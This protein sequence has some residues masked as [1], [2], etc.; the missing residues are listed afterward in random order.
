MKRIVFIVLTALLYEVAFAQMGFNSEGIDVPADHAVTFTDTLV[1]GGGGFR[2][3]TQLYIPEGEGPWPTVVLRTPYL[4]SS[5]KDAWP[6]AKEYAKRGIAYVVQRCRGTGGSEGV[7]EPNIY[8]REDG[9][10]L[11]QW[12]QGESWCK[13]IVLT[14]ASYMALTCWIV[15]D[16]APSKVKGI[17]LH[18]YGVDR[19]LSAYSS[20]LFRQDILTSWAIDNAKE[21]I[22][23]PEK[24][25][26]RMYFDELLHRPQVT[27]DSDMLGAELP[28]YRDWITHTEYTDPYWHEG[29]WETL[30]S[31]PPKIKIPMTIVAGHFDHHMEG[32]I[33][34]YEMLPEET[35]AKSRLIV[36]PWN[37]S[38]QITPDIGPTS[39]A[40]DFNLDADT[41][42]WIH[43]LLVKGEEPSHEVKVYAIGADQWLA[44]KDW[45]SEGG[46]RLSLYLDAST[47]S[48]VKNLAMK[49]GKNSS[50]EYDYDPEDPVLSV[51]GETLFSSFE[52]RGSRPQPEP[53]YR[54]DVITFMSGT[55]SSDYVISG[56]IKATVYF[57][58]D[59]EDT[60]VSF[61]ISEV[62]PDGKAYNIRSGIATLAFREDKLGPRGTY[63]PGTVVPVEIST[64]PVIWRIREGSRLRVDISSSDFPQYSVH[65]N[66]PGVW[67]EISETKVAHQKILTGRKYPSRIDLPDLYSTMSVI[68]G[69]NDGEEEVNIGYGSTSRKNLTSSVSSVRINRNEIST[70]SDIYE[71]LRGRVPGVEVSGSGA[72]AKI[73]IR[74][75]ATVY[76]SSDPLILVDG[77]QITDLS[78]VR[79]GDVKSVEVL[80]D[81]ASCAIYGVQGANG[82]ILIK[83]RDR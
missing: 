12:L 23:H 31:I 17:Y 11:L 14:G 18:H 78:T 10:A 20:G 34:G 54:K 62:F 67:S 50:V 5:F 41:F 42:N 72:N 46:D 19:Y 81:A 57:A 49:A 3:S 37:H 77:V 39:H 15:A 35:K 61:R 2:L 30:R 52:R 47:D 74:G 25:P 4:P 71:Y 36:G 75:V 66:Y 56:Q 6:S 82:V 68:S 24:D 33:L 32:T 79:P 65:S 63:T 44:L 76:G 73:V 7:Y 43:S 27:M 51:G 45:P 22:R 29:V 58:S 28:W 13:N 53:L 9:L 59:A 83:T 48:S 69:Q 21:N 70:Y 1:A 55:F 38:Y 60:A 40:K 80:K 16:S 64:N 26:Q 8:E